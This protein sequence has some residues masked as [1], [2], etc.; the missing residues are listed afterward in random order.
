MKAIQAND[1]CLSI[2]TSGNKMFNTDGVVRDHIT[3]EEGRETFNFEIQKKMNYA[4]DPVTGNIRVVP[5]QYHLERS[6]DGAFIPSASIGDQFVPVQHSAIY[7]YVT[8][9]IMPQ[10][11]NMKLEMVGTLHNCG[12]GVI[13]A[14]WGDAFNIPGDTSPNVLRFIYANP[15]NGTGK[16][17]MG[18]TNVRI[19]CQN[20]LMAAIKQAKGDGWSVKHTKTAEIKCDKILQEI[21]TAAQAA[22]E[23]KRR[24]EVLANIGA[25]SAM[26]TQALDAVYPTYGLE[27]GSPVWKHV[28]DK[29][30]KVMVQFE[31]G[32]TAQ[33]MKGKTAWS[34]FNSFTYP[35]FNEAKITKNTDEAQIA[36]KG[37]LGD[38]A[39]KVREIFAKVEGIAQAA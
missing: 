12:T 36:Y 37:M 23:M 29:R 27:E 10:I 25:T 5:G 30:S 24:S 1:K 34:L 19:V 20:T 33:T 35:I 13:T 15:C 4:Y 28:Q 8:K 11:P 38:T 21:S 2:N 17:T 7:D 9:E 14:T 39:F 3:I 16:L 32:A 26:L 22:L 18:F 6:T 31:S